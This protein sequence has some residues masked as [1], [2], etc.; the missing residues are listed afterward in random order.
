M[1]FPIGPSHRR[2][3][4]FIL[5]RISRSGV[6]FWVRFCFQGSGW[7]IYMLQG[8]VMPFYR[9]LIVSAYILTV[10]TI[11]SIFFTVKAG[12]STWVPMVPTL[13]S[14]SRGYEIIILV[15]GV[16]AREMDARSSVLSKIPICR[17]IILWNARLMCFSFCSY[18]AAAVHHIIIAKEVSILSILY[19]T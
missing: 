10:P 9:S 14:L 17:I 11:M 13:F 18:S 19:C 6:M 8:V 1:R 15:P 3:W 16:L 7:D 2:L 4:I 5:I 12:A